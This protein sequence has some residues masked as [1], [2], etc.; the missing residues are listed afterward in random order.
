V[1]VVEDACSLQGAEIEE[2]RRRHEALGR[3]AAAVEREATAIHVRFGEALDR[4]LLDE[5][6][7]VERDCCP[8]FL[9]EYDDAERCLSVAV[10]EPRMAPAL[11]VIAERMAKPDSRPDPYPAP[12]A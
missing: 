6:I 7:R 12:R 3:S 10:D 4:E 1:G 11:D 8:F 2:Q 5:M 9:I